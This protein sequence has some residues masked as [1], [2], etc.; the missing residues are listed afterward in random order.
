MGAFC[1]TRRKKSQSG[2][3]Q[4]WK[5]N[6]TNNTNNYSKA[7]EHCAQ[8]GGRWVF[9][10][11]KVSREGGGSSGAATPEIPLQCLCLRRLCSVKQE[12]DLW[13]VWSTWK[14]EWRDD[15]E[16]ASVCLIFM[17]SHFSR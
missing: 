4:L 3:Q 5:H 17:E 8:S 11:T 16:S 14:H 9:C 7:I 10:L 1:P 15:N 12:V 2:Q 13:D 6:N